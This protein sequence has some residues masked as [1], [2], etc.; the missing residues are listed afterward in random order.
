[1]SVISSASQSRVTTL[2]AIVSLHCFR[3]PMEV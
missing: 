2:P 1:M 3:C